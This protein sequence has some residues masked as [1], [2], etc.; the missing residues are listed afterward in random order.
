[1]RAPASLDPS[2]ADRQLGWLGADGGCNISQDLVE[3][4]KTSQVVQGGGE[5]SRVVAGFGG[6]FGQDGIADR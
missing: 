4:V 6:G 2:T 1:L 5:M 3:G